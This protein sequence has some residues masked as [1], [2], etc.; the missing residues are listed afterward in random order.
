MKTDLGQGIGTIFALLMLSYLILPAIGVC[1]FIAFNIADMAKGIDPFWV[2]SCRLWT[3]VMIWG[4]LSIITAIRN[5]NK[6][7]RE[8]RRHGIVHYEYKR[9]SR[10]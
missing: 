3:G 6:A 8:K 9:A 10:E 1:V 4:I 2:W 7:Q 5:S